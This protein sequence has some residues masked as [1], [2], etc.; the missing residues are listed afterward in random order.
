MNSYMGN[1]GTAGTGALNARS[2]HAAVAIEHDL[3]AFNNQ[4]HIRHKKWPVMPFYQDQTVSISE[5][6][7]RAKQALDAYPD[8]RPR[9]LIR[10]ALAKVECSVCHFPHLATLGHCPACKRREYA[11]QKAARQREQTKINKAARE[12][13]KCA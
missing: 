6:C 11:R 12:A 5:R 8:D 10:K 2:G 1:H 4:G 7:H 9:K 3:P 13:L